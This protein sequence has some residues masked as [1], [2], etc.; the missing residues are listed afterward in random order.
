MRRTFYRTEFELR[1]LINPAKGMEL[2]HRQKNRRLWECFLNR[3]N[4][5]SISPN[6]R[7]LGN[8]ILNIYVLNPMGEL[9]PIHQAIRL[10]DLYYC[11]QKQCAIVESCDRN[12][13]KGETY[14]ALETELK[15]SCTRLEAILIGLQRQIQ[16]RRRRRDLAGVETQANEAQSREEIERQIGREIETYLRLERETGEHLR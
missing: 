16:E 15:S 11:L 6:A 12:T 13:D 8:A 7:N 5:D 14:G 2:F 3:F 9:L 4:Q 10:F 1:Y